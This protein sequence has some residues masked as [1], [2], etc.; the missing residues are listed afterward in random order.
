M[1][2]SRRGARG[3]FTG[4]MP[5][6]LKSVHPELSISSAAV[7]IAD[8]FVHDMLERLGA[9][10]RTAMRY[11]RHTTL[12]ARDIQVATRLVLQRGELATRAVAEGQRALLAYHKT[13][14]APVV[15]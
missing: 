3:Q 2:R 8:T 9:E 10:A 15:K 11:N 13:R 12:T 6:L 5:S 4:Y 14:V 7:A 1:P